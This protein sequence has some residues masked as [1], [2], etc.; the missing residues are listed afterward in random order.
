[1]FAWGLAV[2][3]RVARPIMSYN[4]DSYVLPR[5]ACE[6]E[7]VG[8][9]QKGRFASFF[10]TADPATVAAKSELVVFISLTRTVSVS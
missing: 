7:F 5:W 4:F 1:M 9:D 2:P 8:R 6:M 3:Q 10:F